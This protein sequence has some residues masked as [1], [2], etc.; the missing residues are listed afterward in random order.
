MM[1][2]FGA[3]MISFKRRRRKRPSV[4]WGDI[5]RGCYDRRRMEHDH[6]LALDRAI[7][8]M[9]M[10]ALHNALKVNVKLITETCVE[11]AIAMAAKF[12]TVDGF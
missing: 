1:Q 3:N 11:D 4:A 5:L 8:V 10:Y 6:Y 2:Q 9:E 12:A 7:S